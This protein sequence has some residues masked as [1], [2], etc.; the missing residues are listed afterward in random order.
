VT[1]TTGALT[2]AVSNTDYASPVSTYIVQTATNSPSNAQVLASLSTGVMKVTTTTGAI[3]TAVANTDFASPSATYIVQ[4]AS[5]APSGAQVLASLTTGMMKVTNTTGVISTATPN[6]EYAV[7]LGGTGMYAQTGTFTSAA[8]TLTALNGSITI[9]N[10]DGVAGNPTFSVADGTSTQKVVVKSPTYSDVNGT[11]LRFIAGTNVSL[12]LTDNSGVADLTINAPDSD[13]NVTMVTLTNATSVVP[14]SFSVGSLTTGMLKNT[15]TG[16]TGAL[17]AAVAN[18]DFASPSSTYIVQTAAAAPS[19]AQVL[20]SLSTG[21][22]KVTTTTGVVSTAVANTDFASPSATY[23]V[24]TATN[25]PSSSQ[26][27]ASLSTGLLKVTTTT[28]ALTTAVA[29]TD[30]Q[31]ANATLTSIAAA[32][33]STGRLLLGNG[34]NSVT[35]L[36]IGAAGTSLT[37]NGTTA[38]WTA[39]VIAATGIGN[40]TGGQTVTIS[41]SAVNGGSRFY[42]TYAPSINAGAGHMYISSVSNGVSFNVTTTSAT[43]NTSQFYWMVINVS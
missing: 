17:T 36:A 31:A 37:S 23:I 28:G 18:T 22:M 7:G 8:R 4:T 40:F 13:L 35:G 29:G 20:A 9:A 5:N 11:T 42:L 24:Q 34:T 39:G 10:G 1:T 32:T 21:L 16:S 15:V 38:S 14:N 3:T 25:A 43:D 6:T 19:G 26:V 33:M 27:L 12:T 30:Y 41:T 2:T